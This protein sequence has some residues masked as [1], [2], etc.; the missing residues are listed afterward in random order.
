[1]R[2]YNGWAALAAALVLITPALAEDSPA[3]RRPIGP[4]GRVMELQTPSHD[5]ISVNP[6]PVP[7]DGIRIQNVGDQQLFISYWDAESSWKTVSIDPGRPTELLC[8]R[9]GGLFTVAFHDG[10][11]PKQIKV[12]SGGTYILGWSEQGNVWVLTSSPS[13]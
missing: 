7:T 6:Q 13:R 1:M 3:P 11:E 5:M 10:K 2:E 9:C 4:Q 12:P 8:R